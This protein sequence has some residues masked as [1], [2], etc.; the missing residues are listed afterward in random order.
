MDCAQLRQRVLGGGDTASPEAKRHLDECSACRD[1]AED[2]GA[3]VRFLADA[4][5]SPDDAPP[6]PSFQ[7]VERLLAQDRRFSTR[8][9]NLRSRTR[10]L[11]ACAASDLPQSKGSTMCLSSRGGKSIPLVD[12]LIGQTLG[13]F[14]VIS[15]LGEGGMGRVY[16][17]EHVLIGRRA[18]IK[19]L[20]AEIAN[21]E[22]FVSRF[23]TEARA[24]N[25]IRHPN[26]VE[27]T[28]FGT[29]GKVPYIVMEL[30]D[31]ETLEQRLARVQKL[32]A[33]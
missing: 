15:L 2:G 16:L 3:L 29:V 33:T 12:T 5:L 32:D 31:G 4:E 24:V 14:R 9:S 23:F 17:A 10:W 28:D 22:D 11:L 30:L 7:E 8:M 26:I 18:A 20:A 6:A 19:V 21:N 27:V 13:S 1:L 25:D